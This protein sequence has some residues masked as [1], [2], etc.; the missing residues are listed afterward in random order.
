MLPGAQERHKDDLHGVE[1][2][3]GEGGGAQRWAVHLIPD[4]RQQPQRPDWYGYRPI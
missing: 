4:R 3:L 2:V 1:E